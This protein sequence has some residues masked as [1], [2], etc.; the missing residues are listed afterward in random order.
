[1]DVGRADEGGESAGDAIHDGCALALFFAFDLLPL[2]QDRARVGC[3]AV[4][5]DVRV[6]ADKFFAGVLRGVLESE[7]AAF[8]GKVGVE[9]D[10]KQKVAEFLAEVGVIGI[11]D[12]VNGLAGFLEESGAEGFVGLLAVPRATVGRAEEADDGAEAGDGFRREL[13]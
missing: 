6:A 2:A 13:V 9:D 4:A 5:E 10:L 12:G 1:L 7:G 11:G 3:V 8:G